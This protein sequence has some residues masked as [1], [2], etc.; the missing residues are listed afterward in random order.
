MLDKETQ[1]VCAT[2]WEL[3]GWKTHPSGKGLV[4]VRA[5]SKDRG[6]GKQTRM[7]WKDRQQRA[8]PVRGP[9]NRQDRQPMISPVRDLASQQGHLPMT[10]QAQD[11]ANQQDH[12]PTTSP[13]RDPASR[14][15]RPRTTNPV[16]DPA[17]Q[18][19]RRPMISLAQGPAHQQGSPRTA[20]LPNHRQRQLRSLVQDLAGQQTM[21]TA[22]VVVTGS[23]EKW[24]PAQTHSSRILLTG[25]RARASSLPY[26]LAGE[27]R[28][29]QI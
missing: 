25:L 5:R 9:G 8:N 28:R 27:A 15:G 4:S 10:N 26:V 2:D 17:S 23:R 1:T 22:T 21:A 3:V 19:G 24:V 7:M 6:R 13:V 18:R 12:L 16:R 20:S 14:Q 29:H 11:L